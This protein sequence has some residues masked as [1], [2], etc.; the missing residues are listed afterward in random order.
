LEP[1]ELAAYLEARL[2]ATERDRVEAHLAVCDPCREEAVTS[3]RTVRSEA[4]TIRGRRAT[5]MLSAA[6]GLLVLI[7]GYSLLANRPTDPSPF[8]GDA[9]DLRYEVVDD[10]DVVQPTDGG[11]VPADS[12]VFVWRAKSADTFYRLT[13]TDAAGDVLWRTSTSDTI[14]VPDGA[15]SLEPGVS[16]FWI[17][18]ALFAG[19]RTATTGAR[20]F[21]IEVPR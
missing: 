11:S 4:R 3:F 9:D 18:D 14:A 20:A 10:I 13:L 8:R 16:Y 5:W 2:S 6:A 7:G 17:V 1:E 21:R 15:V 19:G 12:L